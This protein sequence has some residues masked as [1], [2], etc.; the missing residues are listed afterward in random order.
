MFFS[1]KIPV[2]LTIKTII[3]RTNVNAFENVVQ[4]SPLIMFS[5]M[6]MM[7]AP[8]TAPGIEPIPPNT[9]ATNA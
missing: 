5:Q 8:I 6:P 2:G 9:A 1:P 4:P 7:N 3:K